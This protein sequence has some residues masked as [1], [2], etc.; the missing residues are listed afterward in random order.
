MTGRRALIAHTLFRQVNAI[1]TLISIEELFTSDTRGHAKIDI[2]TRIKVRVTG[3]T[4]NIA[5]SLFSICPNTNNSFTTGWGRTNFCMNFTD[6]T[7][8]Q[9]LFRSH[10]WGNVESLIDGFIEVPFE[11]KLKHG[12]IFYRVWCRL[13]EV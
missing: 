1:G 10:I 5:N 8:F 4:G 6:G 9:V 3:F 12:G 11:S 7:Y 13:G 2:G